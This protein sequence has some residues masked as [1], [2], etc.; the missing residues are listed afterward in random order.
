MRNDERRAD[1]DGAAPL[2]PA[3]TSVLREMRKRKHYECE[4]PWYSCPLS[5]EGCSNPNHG[6]DCTCIVSQIH[7]WADRLE[8][9]APAQEG[10]A[11]A[12]ACGTTTPYHAEWCSQAGE[13]VTITQVALSGLRA[14]L[15]SK[16]ELAEG[17]LKRLDERANK[18]TPIP[19]QPAVPG[20]RSVADD[21]LPP[22]HTMVVLRDEG[23]W[24]KVMELTIAEPRFCAACGREIKGTSMAYQ[25]DPREWHDACFP[26][27]RPVLT[28]ADVRRIVRAEIRDCLR[29]V[30]SIDELKGEL[31]SRI[32]DQ[33]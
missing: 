25:G 20:W 1:R 3:L 7:D 16:T 10:E 26:S 2:T 13:I 12:C 18:V 9:L 24:G 14:R 30:D 28:A 6:D 33:P 23:R 29:G 15:H 19:A 5:D 8:A 22:L 21:G 11:V 17:L 27:N 31:D 4:D 32:K